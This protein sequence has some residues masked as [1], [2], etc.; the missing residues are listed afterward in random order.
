MSVLSFLGLARKAGKV[1]TGEDY[2]TMAARSGKAKLILTASDAGKNTLTR[3]ENAAG[4][5]H[6]PVAALPFTMDELGAALGKSAV[7]AAAITDIHLAH[8]FVEKLSAE[9]AGFED[10]RAGLA[11]KDERAMERQREA[12]R[13]RRNLRIGKS[14]K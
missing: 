8:A 1:E 9:H 14:K 11:E 12:K 7:S 13:H 3:A 5:A 10:I 6:C 4:A 2:I